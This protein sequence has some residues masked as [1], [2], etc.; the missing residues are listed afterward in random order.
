MTKLTFDAWRRL[1]VTKYPAVQFTQESGK[2]ETY[3][4]PG[5]WVAHTGSDMQL[6]VVGTFVPASHCAIY[7]AA[8]KSWTE[9]DVSRE[10]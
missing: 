10:T 2:G 9:F 3:G 1:I 4:E 7:D 6:D 8:T 5:D